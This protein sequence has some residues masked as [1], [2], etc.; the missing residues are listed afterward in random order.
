MANEFP[1]QQTVIEETI[2]QQLRA[3][4]DENIDLT[5]ESVFTTLAEVISTV[6]A[7]NQEKS[8]QE[9][10]E[11]AF[12]ETA[13]GVDLNRVVALAGIQRRDAV[14]ATGIQRFISSQP[15]SQD[16]VIPNGTTVQTGGQNPIRYDTTEEAT[17]QLFD[18]FEATDPLG[19][20]SGDTGGF[21]ITSSN[22]HG[23][24]GALEQTA[25]TF[26]HI[27]NPEITV[28]RGTEM[29]AW[30]R[31]GSGETPRIT[32]G[33][34]DHDNFYQLA[35]DQ[36]VGNVS[37]DR[38]EDFS[39]S[40]VAS[41]T[42]TIPTDEYL[43]VV[44]NWSITGDIS[45]EILQQDGPDETVIASDTGND[46]TWSEGNIGFASTGA[47]S[48]RWDDYTTKAVSANVRAVEGG[49]GGNVGPNTVTNLPSPISGVNTVTNPFAIGDIDYFDTDGRRFI[50]G[51]NR[52]TDE[53]LRERTKQSVSQGGDATA[54]AIISSLINN[55]EG[56]TSV[57]LF[58]NKSDTDN[59]GSG[60]LPPY[61]FEAV[62]FGGDPQI[63]AEEIYDTKAVTARDYGGA[64]G[65]AESRTVV[66]DVNGQEF[67]INFSRPAEVNVDITL[68][69]I[70]TD[71][72]IG[73]EEIRN[74]LVEYIGGTK[75]RGDEAIGL[76][77]GE[78]VIVDQIRDIVVGPDDTGV[79]AF[80]QSVDGSP[81]DTT[82]ST[83]TS[84]GIEIIDVGANE[85]AQTDATDGSITINK[86][87]T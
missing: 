76:G 57:S 51:D 45:F 50:A 43:H 70:V 67:T 49:V 68:D 20:Y 56:T 21:A 11:A 7:N 82:P 2:R 17:L 27:F 36:S 16:Y 41:D 4:F 18:N 79:R 42:A 84:D 61:S 12:L 24:D 19:N 69:I 34:Q 14:H 75:S 31:V 33:V 6:L 1:R 74:R 30:I 58:E 80:D 86:R 73:D 23:G 47:T 63:I 64:N 8:L 59:T 87:Q 72:Y 29:H 38:W 28:K 48:S 15:V 5:E 3:D 37:V 65:T 71:S 55:V 53:E 85:V 40:T 52:E 35:L 9:V 78:D 10:Y 60:G 77:V 13:E 62:V 39:T 25:G 54:D 32:F 66:S 83:T 22:T 81:V 26:S 44:L 46:E